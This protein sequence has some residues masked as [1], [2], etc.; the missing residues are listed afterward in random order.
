MRWGQHRT[1]KSE[2]LEEDKMLGT[3]IRRNILPF[4]LTTLAGV[5]LMVI[6]IFNV[7]NTYSL[8]YR[9]EIWITAVPF[10]SMIY[11]LLSSVPFCW[12]FFYER[13]DGY[14]KYTVNRYPLKRYVIENFVASG[15]WVFLCIFIISFSSAIISLFLVSPQTDISKNVPA[16]EKELLGFILLNNPILYSFILSLWR[17]V[18][19]AI[20]FTFGFVLSLFYNNIFIVMTAPFVYSI[21]ENFTMSILGCPQNSIITS[22][23]PTRLAYGYTALYNLLVGPA[24]LIGITG[25]LFLYEYIKRRKEPGR[26]LNI[27]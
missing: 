5:V 23:M 21:L 14:L 26:C 7:A 8:Y 6:A 24:V 25:L 3:A 10:F 27:I 19:G 11:P 2:Q 4:L 15:L 18:L 20:Y 17:G 22:F 9:I 13:K 1:E 12:R 16:F